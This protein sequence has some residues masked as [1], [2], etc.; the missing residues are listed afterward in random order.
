MSFKFTEALYQLGLGT[1]DFSAD[2]LKVALLMGS[3]NALAS[4]NVTNV[5]AITLDEFDGSGY[6]RGT[7]SSVVWA[8]D[9]VNHRGE[10]TWDPEV[11]AALG[12]GSD[13]VVGALLFKFV[14]NDAG[15]LPIAYYDGGDFP[16]SPNGGD[17]TISS[18]GEGALQIT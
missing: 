13:D 7:L 3:N 2:T 5:G 12:V 6:S 15:S 11:F 17:V 9:T 16:I 18:D 1:V 8:K 4:R 14:T 10:L